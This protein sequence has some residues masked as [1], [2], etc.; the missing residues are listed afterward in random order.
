MESRF[1]NHKVA[2]DLIKRSNKNFLVAGVYGI[3][4]L[5]SIGIL[6][7]RLLRKL[8]PEIDLY[9]YPYIAEVWGTM[10]DWAMVLVTTLTAVF[11][12][13]S[14]R[15]QKKAND[16]SYKNYALAIKPRFIVFEK[17]EET[18]VGK[19]ALIIELKSNP[20]Y[21]FEIREYNDEYIENPKSTYQVTT[22]FPGSKYF[23][24]TTD[25]VVAITGENA[26]SHFLAKIL[27]TDTD[28]NYYQQIVFSTIVDSVYITGP[29]SIES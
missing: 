27:F 9:K 11:L 13:L 26:Q 28:G 15:A 16:I 22:L 21:H 5:A 25:K 19:K 24:L 1:E 7:L 4:F 18:S 8:Y 20:A 10:S 17:M 2:N 3:I 14:F 23:L 12:I 6:T 29:E